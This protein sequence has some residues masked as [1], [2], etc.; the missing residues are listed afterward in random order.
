MAESFLLRRTGIHFASWP[1]DLHRAALLL[2]VGSLVY[3]SSFASGRVILWI[4]NLGIVF[5]DL[6]LAWIAVLLHVAAWP[7][8]WAGLRDLR[9]RRPR[10]TSPVLAWRAFLLT[11][12]LVLPPAAPLPLQYRSYG[13]TDAWFVVL[14]MTA[15]PY[16][17]WTFV[18]LLALHG[19]LF[20]RVAL[21]RPPPARRIT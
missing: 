9:A 20:R 8:L 15:F 18:P 5:L 13:S 6:F 12:A 19:V 17:A 21:S 16:L 7:R 11:L 14:Y 1:R 2:G 3:W 10:E 4:P